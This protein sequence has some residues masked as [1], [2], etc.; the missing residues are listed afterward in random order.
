MTTTTA[1]TTSTAYDQL[2]G[3]SREGGLLGSIN[4]LLGW[5]QE[6]TMPP[7]GAVYRASQLALLARL[8]HER[9][10]SSET[11]ELISACEGE[12]DVSA[13]TIEAANL[14]AW[15]HDHDRAVRLPAS[16]VEELA[17]VPEAKFN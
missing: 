6:T 14:R 7:G 2:A 13:D 11:G 17:A 4:G 8:S 3:I 16:L 15:R 10:A 9:M 1:T 12:M 5:D